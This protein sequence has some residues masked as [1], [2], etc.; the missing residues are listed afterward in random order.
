MDAKKLRKQAMQRYE[1]NESPK[2]IYQCIG[3]GKIWF[4]I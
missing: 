3:K 2:E 1:N 4:F